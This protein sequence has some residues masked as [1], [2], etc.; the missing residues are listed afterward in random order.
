LRQPFDVTLPSGE[1]LA[2]SL[3]TPD[4][5][6]SSSCGP[7]WADAAPAV[8][9]CHGLSGHKVEDGRLF[10]RLARALAADGVVSLRFDFRGSGDSD[11]DFA[12]T[13]IERQLDDARAALHR[14]VGAPG[15]DTVR[16]AVLGLSMGSIVASLLAGDR[17]DLAALVLWATVAHP[18]ELFPPEPGGEPRPGWRVEPGFYASCA[19]TE[20]LA[21]L[22]RYAGPLLC[23]HGT[24]DYVPRGWAE[25]ARATSRH[26][27]SRLELVDGEHTF[28][29]D[30]GKARAI[31]L[32]RAW[33]RGVLAPRPV[34]RGCITPSDGT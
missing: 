13:T 1:I 31:E 20:P 23:V 18:G 29:V 3:E 10:V 11:G 26:P 28:G 9:L 30:A 22:A 34:T 5:P 15:V 6:G 7:Q 19:R 32:T 25:A 8:L 16:I 21:A 33:L 24:R 27:A 14:L 4:A 12:D 17:P 2:A